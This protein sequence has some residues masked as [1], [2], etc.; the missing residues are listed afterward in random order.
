[1]LYEKPKMELIVFEKTNDVITTSGGGVN[2][3]GDGT[4]NDHQFGS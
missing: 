3:E 1:M 4:G 2:I